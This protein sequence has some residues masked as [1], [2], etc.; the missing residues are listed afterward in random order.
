MTDDK[1]ADA[2]REIVAEAQ[3]LRVMATNSGAGMV[4]F[5]LENVLHEARAELGRRG[6]PLEPEGGKAGNN[7]VPLRHQ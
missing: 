2:L 6:L 7:V 5:L 4:A 3:H 1:V